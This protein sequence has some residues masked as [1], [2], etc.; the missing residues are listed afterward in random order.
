MTRVTIVPVASG[1]D[2]RQFIELPFR[3]YRENPYWVAPLRGDIQ[4][5]LT[6]GRHPVHAE[7]DISPFLACAADRVVGR[8][9]AVRNRAHNLA[10]ADRVGFFGFFECENDAEVAAALLDAARAQLA[11]AGL[12]RVR[13]PASPSM[14]YECGLLVD[15]FDAMPVLKMPYNPP[16]Y[17]AQLEAA[18]L[19]QVMD[20]HAFWVD[21]GTL[22]RDEK[23]QRILARLRERSEIGVRMLDMKRFDRDVG[24][25]HRIYN[26]AWAKN[27]GFHPMS[28]AEFRAE[29]QGL[30]YLAEPPLCLFAET[31]GVPIAFL[32][33]LRDV[34]PA[35]QRLR[36]RLFS[37]ALL[38]L[39][40]LRR[41]AKR[42]RIA[43]AGALPDKRGQGVMALLYDQIIETGL[44]RGIEACEMSWVLESNAV[45]RHTAEAFGARVYR[46]YRM[47]EGEVAR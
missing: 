16:W 14:H 1:R 8:I 26:E 3:L 32:V 29:A 24:I 20:L 37:P 2:R 38:G 25:M 17:A 21:R 27:W 22:R 41:R 10:H 19:Q 44:E 45:M 9:A 7:L 6:P 4:R 34:N 39:L 13:G 31:E 12:D 46:T 5:L 47:Y 40:R 43:I 36:G 42:M 23:V 18:G 35:L 15:S 28:E 11:S 33:A 30:R